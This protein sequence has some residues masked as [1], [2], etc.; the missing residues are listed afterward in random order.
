MARA[1]VTGA[2]GF[3]GRWLTRA[4]VERGH[5]V[6]GTRLGDAGAGDADDGVSAWYGGD[7]RDPATLRAAVEGSRPELVFHLAG[8]SS[9]GEAEADAAAAV[10]INV[11]ATG[12]LLQE[13]ARARDGGVREPTVL[14]VGSGEQYGR[15]DEGELPLEEDAEQRPLTMY[16]AT[17]AAQE[18]IA[19]QGWRRHGLRVVCTRSFNHTG[20]GQ[21]DRFLLPALVARALALRSA[22]GGELRLGNTSPI[23]DFTHVSDVVAAYILL[24]ERGV[25]GGVYNVCRGEGTSV[26]QMAESVLRRVGVAARL[27]EDPALVRPVDVPALVGDPGRLREETGWTPRNTLDDCIDDLINAAT[28]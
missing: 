16:A 27:V 2:A 13:L 24:A 26:R 19:L 8:I 17:K 4:L 21:S 9:V 6:H 5:T 23:R 11:A 3:V 7:L 12:R 28:H 25:A 20:A 18:T 10:E 14:V 1:L 15:H 22:G